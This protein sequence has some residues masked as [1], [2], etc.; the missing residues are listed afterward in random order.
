M[1]LLNFIG[2]GIVAKTKDT[3][4]D[5][6]LVYLPR[7]FP[8]ADGRVSADLKT[9]DRES[10]NSSGEKVKSSL[11]HSNTVPAIWKRM[12]DSSRITSPDVREGSPV[13]LY[14]VSGQNQYYWTLYGVDVKTFRMETVMYG[15]NANPKLEE[16]A[17]FDIDSYYIF[18]VDTRTGLM[19][20][21]TSQANGEVSAF[22]IQINAMEGVIS[23]G[24]SNKS[25]LV[26]DDKNHS[27]T[28]TND[29]DSLFNIDKK[30]A[31][32]Y[33]KDKINLFT[34]E[35]INIKTKVLNI[36]AEEMNVDIKLTRWKGKIERTGDTEQDG[37][38]DA[39]G[40]IHSD[41]DVTSLV[42]LNK[43]K[44]SGV[45]RGNSSTDSPVPGT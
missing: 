13:A 38:Y 4:T 39:T 11:L 31:S 30:V 35:G 33:T 17:D 12:G 25:Y 24:G 44:H 45:D 14:Q 15:W 8:N 6:I 7:M 40:E 26:F 16:D 20:I 5:E 41:T 1:N 10:V 23:A 2:M 18:K 3:N 21:R 29:E 42:S 27:F 22:D 34:E 28:Y 37:R 32:I 19:A 43:H 9:I 36:Q